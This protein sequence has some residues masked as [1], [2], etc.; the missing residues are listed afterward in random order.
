MVL[1][2]SLPI[3]LLQLAEDAHLDGEVEA[4]RRYRSRLPIKWIAIAIVMG[5][6]VTLSKT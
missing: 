4:I 5:G 6:D 3:R 1:R 2:W